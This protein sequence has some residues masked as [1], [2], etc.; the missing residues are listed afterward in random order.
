MTAAPS[1]TPSNAKLSIKVF[2][3]IIFL[4]LYLLLWIVDSDSSLAK[5]IAINKSVNM[6]TVIIEI[7]FNGS[8]IPHML[9]KTKDIILA[10][11]DVSVNKI[12]LIILSMD[13]L[14][15][16]IAGRRAKNESFWWVR[17]TSQASIQGWLDVNKDATETSAYLNEIISLTLS[18]RIKIIFTPVTATLK[19][20]V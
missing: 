12:D 4:V 6:E 18:Y 19:P 8:G 15:S 1:I 17:V 5:P 3:V 14:D 11:V 20:R 10:E 2:L 13:L 16:M 7:S 9:K